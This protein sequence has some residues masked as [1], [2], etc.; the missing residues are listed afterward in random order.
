M[1]LPCRSQN[2]GG[3]SPLRSSKK[4]V[5]FVQ[6]MLKEEED[7]LQCGEIM[8]SPVLIWRPSRR[9]RVGRGRPRTA[10]GDGQH[11]KGE[12]DGGGGGGRKGR[13]HVKTTNLT[14]VLPPERAES[15]LE[16]KVHIP[17]V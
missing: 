16:R 15:G 7:E 9:G 5:N 8:F 12:K 1:D 2:Q 3:E 10:E 14:D 4:G 17:C 11:E 13:V 6:M